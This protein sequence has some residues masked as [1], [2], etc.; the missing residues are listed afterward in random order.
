[1]N[2]ATTMV[3]RTEI[4]RAIVVEDNKLE[5]EITRKDW[6]KILSRRA[7]FCGRF[8]D[9]MSIFR[10]RKQNRMAE[11]DKGAAESSRDGRDR[12]ATRRE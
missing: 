3:T 6:H 9:K 1:M 5:A 8:V 11:D 2:P 12:R 10:E 4:C 7:E